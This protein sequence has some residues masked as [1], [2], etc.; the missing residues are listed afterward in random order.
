[1]PKKA[2]LSEFLLSSTLCPP[3]NKKSTRHTKKQNKNKYKNKKQLEETE[4]ASEPESDMP[5]MLKLS[6]LEFKTTMNKWYAKG[7][8]GKHVRTGG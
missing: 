4:Q 6:I 2:S 8:S 3:L 1:M 5:G 7:S